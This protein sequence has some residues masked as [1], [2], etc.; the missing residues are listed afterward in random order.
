VRRQLTALLALSLALDGCAV[1]GKDEQPVPDGAWYAI[2]LH[3]H[4]SVGSNDTDGLSPVVQI[5]DV[6]RA[7]GLSLVV[8]TDHSNSAGS[9]DCESGDVEDCPNQGPEFPSSIEAA[10]YSDE[11]LQLVA[12]VEISPVASLESTSEPTGHIGCIPRAKTSFEDV[13]EPVNDRPVGAT[14]GGEGIAWCRDQGGFSILNHPFTLAP[15]INYDWSSLEY[16]AM[17]IFNG[18]GRFDSGD[19]D[20]V[21]SWACDV[22]QGRTVVP[23]GGSDTHRVMTPSPPEGPLDQALGFPSTWVWSVSADAD[24]LLDALTSGRTMVGDPRTELSVLA[25]SGDHHAVPGQD[26]NVSERGLSLQIEVEV[27]SS[28]LRLEVIDLARG[29]C[30]ADERQAEGTAAVIDPS[31]LYSVTLEPDRKLEELIDLSGTEAERIVVWVRPVT[32]TAAGMDGFALASPI[33]LSFD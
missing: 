21:Q 29:A 1:S 8:I 22:S 12:G 15:W 27:A 17:E 11:T 23:V 9:M 33:T 3:V 20:A 4:S 18:G 2:D 14:S 7:R 30:V 13:S 5:A 6:A 31:V 24:S 16:D 32:I 25:L 19:W 10:Q 26:L 28:G